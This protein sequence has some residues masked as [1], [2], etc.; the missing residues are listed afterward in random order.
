MANVPKDL[1]YSKEHEWVQRMGNGQVRVGIT[2]FAQR[3]LGDIVFVELPKVGDRLDV[4]RAF[5][6]VES[7]K[8]VSELYMPVAGTIV[9][10]NVDMNDDP[11][12]IN[13]DPYDGW[14]IEITLAKASDTDNLLSAA[15]Y[16]AYLSEEAD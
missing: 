7:V 14:M 10:V 6:S 4:G 11:E 1:M 5:G 16:E 15:Q 2:D 13:Q 8:A 3:Q 12:M 9:A